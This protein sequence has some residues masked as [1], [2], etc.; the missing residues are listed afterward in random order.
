MEK[1]EYTEPVM[2]LVEMETEDIILTSAWDT[3][4]EN[5]FDNN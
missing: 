3:D 5:P 2:E 1:R 4:V